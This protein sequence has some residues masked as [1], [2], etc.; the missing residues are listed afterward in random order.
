[1][2]MRSSWLISPQDHARISA[3]VAAAEGNSDGEIATM[4]ARRSDDYGDWALFLAAMASFAKLA[5]L[6]LWADAFNDLLVALSGSWHSH[7]TSAELIAAALGVQMLVFAL[8]WL[9]LRWM[10][11]R[12][13]LTPHLIK[14][15]RVRREALRA[16][17]IG[18]EARTRASTGVL[19][20]LSLAE[21]SAEIVADAAITSKVGPSE[22][23]DAMAALITEV[24][25]D[26]PADGIV[27]AVGKV[28]ALI[29]LHFPRR[30]DDSNEMP[31]R[32]IEL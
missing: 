14:A 5:A 22:W 10:P 17:R 6:A 19:V 27:A 1:M 3:A 8:A 31:D 20:Y 16:F 9:A 2:V 11:L 26:R 13:A 30:H 12:L 21:R 28:G 18:I 15:S 29:A 7:F 23:G 4:L 25:A 32:L 24:K